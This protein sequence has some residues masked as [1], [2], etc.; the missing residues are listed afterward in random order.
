MYV[1]LYKTKSKLFSKIESK[2]KSFIVMLPPK[3]E[4]LSQYWSLH[5]HCDPKI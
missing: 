2:R 1:F 4:M 3:L 5:W